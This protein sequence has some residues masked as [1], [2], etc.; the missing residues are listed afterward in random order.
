MLTLNWKMFFCLTPLHI[1]EN[2]MNEWVKQNWWGNTEKCIYSFSI[3]KV[4]LIV[5]VSFVCFDS[6]W[7]CV[8]WEWKRNHSASS[9]SMNISYF[10]DWYLFGFP[11]LFCSCLGLPRLVLSFNG[12]NFKG[13]LIKIYYVNQKYLAP[14]VCACTFAVPFKIAFRKLSMGFVCILSW[15]FI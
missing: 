5:S 2:R 3:V 12:R 9:I 13:Q 1:Y 15:V 7:I 6:Y 14:C 4:S 8:E 11:F 10:I